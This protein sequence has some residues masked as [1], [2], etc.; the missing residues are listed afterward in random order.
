MAKAPKSKNSGSVPNDAIPM[1]KKL[2]MGQN[3]NT[4]SGS[5]KKTP[6]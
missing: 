3:P 5:G 1:H 4:G 6:A 2:A